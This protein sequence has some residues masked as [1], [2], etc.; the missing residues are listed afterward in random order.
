M[1]N[2]GGGIFAGMQAQIS[3]GLKEGA[4]TAQAYAERIIARLDV[5][6][7]GVLALSKSET[8]RAFESV[9]V[10]SGGTGKIETKVGQLSTIEYVSAVMDGAGSVDVFVGTEGA[11]GFRIRLNATVADNVASNLSEFEVP[12]GAPIFIKANGTA[13]TVNLQLKRE[14]EF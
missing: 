2:E 10:V 14:K 9:R 13:A 3:A 4:T 6:A 7:E 11:P 12:S 5:I 1:R 8:E